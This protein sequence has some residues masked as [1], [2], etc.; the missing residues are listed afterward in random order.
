MKQ[1]TKGA[2]ALFLLILVSGQLMSQSIRLV[3]DINQDGSGVSRTDAKYFAAVGENLFFVANDGT[4]GEELWIT[5]GFTGS[6]SMVMDIFPGEESSE[7]HGLIEHNGLCYFFADDGVNGKELWSSNGTE[8]GTQMIVDINVGSSS[9]LFSSFEYLTSYNGS[10]YFEAYDGDKDR[11]W[12]VDSNGNASIFSGLPAVNFNTGITGLHVMDND[13]YF[14]RKVTFDGLTLY[15]FDGN[16]I[17][18]IEA[19]GFGNIITHIDDSDG[20][21]FYA[22]QEGFDDVVWSYDSNTGTN[23]RHNTS[24]TVHSAI[25]HNSKLYYSINSDPSLYLIDASSV[26]PTILSETTASF[27][28]EPTAF[29][30]FNNMVYYFGET[31][32]DGVHRT[33][34]TPG[35]TE[36]LFDINQVSF[37]RDGIHS[38]GNQLLIAGETSYV[39]G[40]ELFI[41]DGES[42]ID[43]FSDI[44]PNSN[45]SEPTGFID[46][47]DNRT[48]FTATT[49]DEG[50]E[51]W[52]YSTFGL[53]TSQVTTSSFSVYPSLVTNLISIDNKSN[54]LVSEAVVS[55][56]DNQGLSI[57]SEKLTNLS[58]IDAERWVPGVYY[59]KIEVQGKKETHKVIKL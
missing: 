43:I 27:A 33:D 17:T 52:M 39:Q 26:E 7:L 58:N 44:N 3:K 25:A 54:S 53:S 34:G 2:F 23:T 22:I 32:N 10:L 12:V 48:F 11:F 40:E 19:F 55:I 56:F 35:G 50:R 15:K 29:E 14:F 46:V 57:K 51:L 37:D 59:I 24:S 36:L 4:S 9:S 5:D 30:V 8:A 31:S 38:I 49:Q 42:I 41:S 47:G 18:S 16:V 21:L 6:T 13:L 20:I 45:D 1:L 28:D